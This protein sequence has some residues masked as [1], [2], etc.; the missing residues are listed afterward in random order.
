MNEPEYFYQRMTRREKGVYFALLY[1]VM[2]LLLCLVQ[3]VRSRNDKALWTVSRNVSWASFPKTDGEIIIDSASGE[4]T[5]VLRFTNT[6]DAPR[7]FVVAESGRWLPISRCGFA[8]EAAVHI[9]PIMP[10]SQENSAVADS[11]TELM[12]EVTSGGET[13]RFGIDIPQT[14]LLETTIQTPD[15]R[16]P[17]S[18]EGITFRLLLT[19]PAQT[20][21]YVCPLTLRRLLP[22]G[23][24]TLEFLPPT[25]FGYQL[26]IPLR[27]TVIALLVLFIALAGWKRLRTRIKDG[28]LARR[29]PYLALWGCFLPVLILFGGVTALYWRIA[30]VGALEEIDII[31]S[32]WPIILAILVFLSSTFMIRV[33]HRERSTRKMAAMD[34]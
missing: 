19:L 2:L 3:G 14:N 8:L 33:E 6:T 10:K 16:F 18:A 31:F 25:L 13:T 27:V 23:T 4:K 15:G 21:A 7:E 29:H 11:G 26:V 1:V 22:D 24:P 30:S 12:M 17:P 20:Q 28:I 9:K 32:P 34:V 5:G